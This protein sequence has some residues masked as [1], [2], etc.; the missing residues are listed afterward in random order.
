MN[1]CN[2]LRKNCKV[3]SYSQNDPQLALPTALVYSLNTFLNKDN[4]LSN[5]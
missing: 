3:I 1:D 5:Q 2:E 4:W